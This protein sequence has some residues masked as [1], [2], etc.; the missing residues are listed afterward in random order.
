MTGLENGI[1]DKGDGGFFRFTDAKVTL[2]NRRQLQGRKQ[3]PELGNLSGI[4]AGDDQTVICAH[5]ASSV[6]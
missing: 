3:I 4:I 5:K 2:R 6:V 1:L